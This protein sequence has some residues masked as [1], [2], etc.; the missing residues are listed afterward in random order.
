MTAEVAEALAA[1]TRDPEMLRAALALHRNELPIAERILKPRLKRDPYDFVAMRLL[2]ELATRLAR[3]RDAEVLL[4]RVLELAP[5]FTVARSNLALLLYRANRPSE[6][7]AEL[8]RLTDEDGDGNPALRAAAFG[9]LGD[10]AEALALYERL[11]AAPDAPPKL[12]LSY[13]HVLKTVGRVAEGIAAYTRAIALAPTLGEAWWSLANL[14]THRFA[15][16]D[17][18]AMGAALAT[19]GLAAE[20]RFHLEFT[21]GKAAEDAGDAARAFACYAAANAHRRALIGYD[22]AATRRATERAR[23]TFT[24]AFFAARPRH[25]LASDAPIFIIGLPRSGSTLIEQILSCHALVEPT[26]ELPAIPQMWHALG[27]DPFAAVG[28]LD[29]GEAAALGAQYLAR[30]APQRRTDKPHFVDKL[31]NNWRYVGFIK[32]ILPAAKIID[33]RRH[34]LSCGWSNF[35]Q[36]FARGQHFA[37]DLADIG[38]YYRDYVALLAGFAHAQ[39]G[40]VHRVVY[41]RMVEHPEAEIRALLAA[42]GLPFEPACLAFHE[43]KRAVRTPSSEQV[44][45]PIFRS[46]LENW[47]AF[48]PWLGP[49]KA[50]LGDVL[51]AYP[52][53]PP[54]LSP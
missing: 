41:E 37:Y 1:A 48:E 32:T 5:R 30:V 38:A 35:R 36:H 39:P 15:E 9:R 13:G 28:S 4:R 24:A 44:R 47:Q 6:A 51:D 50:A 20:D 42:L 8:D 19:P 2:A 43:N 7:L 12:W 10:F 21:L 25:G 34:P 31:P 27:D 54:A 14:K 53:V 40:A 29:A 16:A 46:G 3:F 49:L 52:A 22:A 18:A 45:A 23:A 17:V 33:A 26:D 11:V